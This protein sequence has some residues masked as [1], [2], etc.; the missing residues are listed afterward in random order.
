MVIHGSNKSK[1]STVDN[2]NDMRKEKMTKLKKSV[3]DAKVILDNEVNKIRVD[4][5]YML[6]VLKVM[7]DNKNPD[8]DI[9]QSKI[10]DSIVA[11]IKKDRAFMKKAKEAI[12]QNIIAITV[13]SFKDSIDRLEEDIQGALFKTLTSDINEYK[14]KKIHE[15]DEIF[16][17]YFKK[18]TEIINV[19]LEEVESKTISKC[20]EVQNKIEKVKKTSSN[21]NISVPT[22]HLKEIQ[23]YLRMIQEDE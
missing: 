16:D 18:L 8:N 7:M 9:I 22:K 19:K 13:K 11:S 2:I 4:P 14:D 21:S 15:L 5:L 23:R 12:M 10:A 1:K 6:P 20:K 3:I 17:E